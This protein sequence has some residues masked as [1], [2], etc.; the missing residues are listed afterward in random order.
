M[1]KYKPNFER[2]DELSDQ[3]Y[4]RKVTSACGKLCLYNYTDQTTYEKKWNEHTLNARGT[5]YEI[6][7][8][9]MVA[10]AFPKFFNFGELAT[11]KS[12]NLLKKTKFEVYEKMDG[13]LGIIYFYDDEW[14]VNTR[15][16]FSSDQ[17]I[18]ATQMLKEKYDMTNVP[19]DI[20][21]L[22][23]IIYPENRIIVDYGDEE[24]LTVI[25]GYDLEHGGMDLMDEENF[26][27]FRMYLKDTGL[28][29]AP[30]YHDFKSIDE[31]IATQA[32]LGK[33]EEGFVVRFENGERVKFKSAEYLKVA[34]LLSQLTPL[35]F[36]KAMKDGVV[37]QEIIEEIPEEFRPE[38]DRI[39]FGLE[40]TYGVVR[41]EIEDDYHYAIK[42]IGGIFDLSED[43]KKLG[44]FIKENGSE[45]KH[46][47]AMFPMLLEG[48]V[49]KY[50]MREIRP[51]GNEI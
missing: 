15:G 21:I 50:I 47:T 8:G 1:K 25:G 43:R 10:K 26:Y 31:V 40:A 3:G 13:S 19:T 30:R 34:R 48:D 7:T 14:R 33:M 23:E 44:L 49:D 18:K 11:S 51:K 24:K 38:V 2:L 32:Q 41:A 39:K 6:A 9:K 27:T 28:E 37:Q 22:A 17:A 42:S 20:T 45:L 36:W 29:M 4:L 46:P 16:S 5:V 12:R 35:N